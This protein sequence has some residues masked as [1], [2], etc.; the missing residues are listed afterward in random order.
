MKRPQIHLLQCLLIVTCSFVVQPCLSQ[1]KTN[2][3]GSGYLFTPVKLLE[4]TE[5]QN[6]QATN[7]SGPFPLF[8]FLRVS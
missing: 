8:P 7:T 5:V 3:P 2:K 6:Q 1:E 4:A